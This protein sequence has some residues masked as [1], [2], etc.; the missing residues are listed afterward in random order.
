MSGAVASADACSLAGRLKPRAFYDAACRNSL[1]RLVALI[2]MAPRRSAE[3]LVTKAEATSIHFDETVSDPILNYPNRSPIERAELIAGWS[4]AGGKADRTAIRL[5]EV[6]S[7]KSEKGVALL[8]FTL[9]RDQFHPADEGCNGL[10]THGD[11]YGPERRSYLGTFI[12]N[13][14]RQVTAFDQWLRTI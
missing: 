13:D 12:N 9:Q 2:R 14:L 10:F 4:M 8:Q 3:E 11:F 6:N 1:D 5:I 7:L